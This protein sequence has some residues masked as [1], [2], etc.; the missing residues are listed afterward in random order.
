MVQWASPI[1]Q[2]IN[3][4]RWSG[5]EESRVFQAAAQ[6]PPVPGLG[7][8]ALLALSALLAASARRILRR[9]ED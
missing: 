9:P 6:A 3:Y 1:D 8:T 7:P 4:T 2:A 5:V